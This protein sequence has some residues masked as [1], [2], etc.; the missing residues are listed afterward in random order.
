MILLRAVLA[1]ALFL[2]LGGPAAQARSTALFR[3]DDPR[4]A[5]ISGLAIGSRSP[6]ARHVHNASGA[7]AS[8][9]ALDRRT[10]RVLAQYDRARST[11]WTR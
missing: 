9:L 1:A 11:S 4:L 5:E 8:F 2:G 10:A 6:R 3:C 7:S